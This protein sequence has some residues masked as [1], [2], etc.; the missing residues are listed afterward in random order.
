[1]PPLME[2]Q[3]QDGPAL[4]RLSV[5]ARQPVAARRR[6]QAQEPKQNEK[7]AGKNHS[8][9]EVTTGNTLGPIAQPGTYAE[10]NQE[11]QPDRSEEKVEE[12]KFVARVRVGNGSS[13]LVRRKRVGPRLLLFWIRASGVLAFGL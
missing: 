12:I 13:F 10:L 4:D 2:S 3:N 1:M 8:L 7:H 9:K 5:V 6:G 11:N